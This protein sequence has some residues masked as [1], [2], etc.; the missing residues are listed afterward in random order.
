MKCWKL[1]IRVRVLYLECTPVH[2]GPVLVP[3]LVGIT[4]QK[5]S[6][7]KQTLCISDGAQL[8]IK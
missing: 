5:N 4:M 2:S 1:H 7:S 6:I 3:C 8:H